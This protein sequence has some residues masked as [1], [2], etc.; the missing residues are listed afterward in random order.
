MFNLKSREEKPHQ[1]DATIT[2]LISDLENP[3]LDS[4]EFISIADR[5]ARFME[6]RAAEKAAT[7][8]DS[9][10]A[11]RVAGIAAN[12]LSIALILGFEKANVLTSKSLGFV[13]KIQN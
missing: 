5:L 2:K 13:P 6:I 7:K 3:S 12:L 8:P 1:L 9:I 10:T 4:K 11:D